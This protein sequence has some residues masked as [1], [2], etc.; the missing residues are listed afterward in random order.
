MQGVNIEKVDW[1]LL[2]IFNSS[3]MDRQIEKDDKLM[4]RCNGY[5]W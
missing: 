1:L 2:T 4:E 3:E 5:D